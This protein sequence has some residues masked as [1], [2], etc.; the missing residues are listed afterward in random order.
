M[1]ALVIDKVNVE[2]LRF[3]LTYDP[4]GILSE[5]FKKVGSNNYQINKSVPSR[6]LCLQ[7]SIF[8]PPNPNS[9]EA[10]QRG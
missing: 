9:S 6:I 5:N 10:A 4:I 2:D 8:Y 7:G 3:I 1:K